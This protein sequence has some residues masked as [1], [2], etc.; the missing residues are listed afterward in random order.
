MEI[1]EQV[2]RLKFYIN[3]LAGSI[4]T[5][6]SNHNNKRDIKATIE[7]WRNDAVVASSLINEL[8][9]ELDDGNTL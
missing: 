1:K 4:D 7:V 9:D 8:M 2:A 6:D 3:D 5:Y